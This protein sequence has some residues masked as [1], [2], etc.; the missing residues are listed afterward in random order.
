MRT[1]P[2]LAAT[3]ALAGCGA[4]ETG[5]TDS[6]PAVEACFVTGSTGYPVRLEVASDT[7]ARQKGLMGREKLAEN[8]GMVFEY[9]EE[10][11]AGYGFWMFRTLIPLDIAFLDDHGVIVSLRNM[12][13]CQSS[14]ST[15]C[16]SYPAGAPFW[17]AVEMNSGY[18]K[19]R[20]INVGD[21]L[22]WPLEGTCPP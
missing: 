4:V 5:T 13:P 19:A 1:L 20:G 8:A 22:I 3:L 15:H 6:L 12:E 21:R 2:F 17:N 11:G 9:Q 18:F 10:R 7:S 16:P 14:R